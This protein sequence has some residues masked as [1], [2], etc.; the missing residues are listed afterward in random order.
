MTR[1][2]TWRCDQA[3]FFRRMQKGEVFTYADAFDL[4]MVR[5]LAYNQG[6]MI[7]YC[8]PG[9]DEY[10]CHGCNTCVVSWVQRDDREP[11]ATWRPYLL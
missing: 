7:E 9:T 5:E 4:D 11:V 8:P 10:R 6:R 1:K 3:N 2:L